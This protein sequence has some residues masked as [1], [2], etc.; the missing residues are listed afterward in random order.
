MQT[1]VKI[2]AAVIFPAYIMLIAMLA[3]VVI[4]GWMVMRMLE[5]LG[6]IQAF[7]YLLEQTSERLRLNQIKRHIQ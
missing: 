4:V 7:I 2:A 1:K 5:F 6:I 3:I